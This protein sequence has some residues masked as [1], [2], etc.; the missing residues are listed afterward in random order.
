MDLASTHVVNNTL[1]FLRQQVKFIPYGA[2]PPCI[3]SFR[4][5]KNFSAA[6]KKA[7]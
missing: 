3:A 2:N 6:L 4:L 1:N 7:V 5:I